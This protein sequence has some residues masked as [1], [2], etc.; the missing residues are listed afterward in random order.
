LGAKSKFLPLVCALLATACVNAV[1]LSN[2]ATAETF[3]NLREALDKVAIRYQI[4]VGLEYAPQ[5]KDLQ[6]I[7]L[8]LSEK[9]VDTVLNQLAS[10]KTDYVWAFADNVYD[11]FPKSNSD[12]ILD[13]HIREFEIKALSSTEALSAVGEIPEIKRWLASHSVSRR[14]L[15]VCVGSCGV[16]S[17]KLVTL[18]L[19]GITFRTLLNTLVREFGTSDWMICRYGD[20][21]EY[22]G[23]YF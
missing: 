11:I 18:F 16:H 13:V 21:Q 6:P 8:D 12:S 19:K 17:E 14:E 5:D 22:I 10:Q 3:T 7:S 15:Y 1:A 9:S 23:I 20:R 2:P 4:R